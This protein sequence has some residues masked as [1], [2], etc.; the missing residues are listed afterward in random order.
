MK[1]CKAVKFL[2]LIGAIVIVSSCN[3]S[4][5]NE[6]T[7]VI[8]K[9]MIVRMSEIEIFPEYLEEYK[10]ILKYEAAASVNIEPGV[11]AI[12]PMYQIK[13]STQV[14]SVEIY[15]NEEA[16][17]SHLKTPHFLYYKTETLKMVKDLKLVDMDNIDHETMQKIFKKMK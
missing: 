10:K 2:M 17:Q 15:A 3:S 1:I 12:F 4:K 11:I 5:Q 8:E 13:D 14:R 16:Y 9:D 7:T 6:S